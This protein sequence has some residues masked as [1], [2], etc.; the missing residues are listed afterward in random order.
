MSEIFKSFKENEQA[1]R[2]VLKGYFG[3]TADI[4]DLTQETF[5]RCFAA[6]SKSHIRQPKSYLFR[7]AKNLAVSEKRRKFRKTT[8]Y[9]E[10]S[11]GADARVDESLITEEDRLDSQRKLALLAEAIASLPEQYRK[12][13]LMR[14]MEHL[15][16]TQIAVRTNV[17]KRTAQKRVAVALDMCATYLQNKGYEPTEFGRSYLSQAP[18]AESA[19]ESPIRLLSAA[20]RRGHEE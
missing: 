7:A 17:T 20:Q 14:K 12:A 6:E 8:D 15:K 11:G 13:I 3:E 9:L 4:D 1:I 2:R 5:L 18:T 16:L 10:D 19:G